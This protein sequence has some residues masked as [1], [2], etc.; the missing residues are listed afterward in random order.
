MPTLQL[1][2][3]ISQRKLRERS[4]N[5]KTYKEGFTT[6]HSNG[7]G[8]QVTLGAF[9]QSGQLRLRLERVELANPIRVVPF[10]SSILDGRPTPLEVTCDETVLE[11]NVHE[12]TVAV[13]QLLFKIIK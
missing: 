3:Y 12:A 8:R 5:K 4:D 11:L 9:L 6:I 13:V 7:S 2:T 10:F 1:Q